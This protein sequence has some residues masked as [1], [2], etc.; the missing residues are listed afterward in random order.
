MSYLEEIKSQLNQRDFAKLLVLWEE[1]C[2]NDTV[3]V[4]EYTEILKAIKANDLAIPFGKYVEHGL[5]I[6]NLI[7]NPEEAYKVLQLILDL[8][9]TNSSALADISTDALKKKFANDPDFNER[10]RLVGLR[11][12]QNFQGSISNYEL[13]AHMKKGKYVFHTGGWDAGEIADVSPVREQLSVEFEFVAGRKHFTFPNAFKTLIPLHDDHFLSRRFANP[14]L[15]EQQARDNPNEIIHI[16]LRDLGP[17][18]AA[19]IKDE[20]CEL[21]IPEKDWTKWWQWARTKL[22]K[23]PLVET[24]QSLKQP[25]RLRKAELTEKDMLQQALQDTVTPNEIILQCYNLVRDIPAVL[26]NPDVNKMLRQS[27][28]GLLDSNPDDPSIA[29]QVSIFFENTFNETL[30]G[31]SVASLIQSNQDIPNLIDGI[32]ILAYKKR[33]LV[34]IREHRQDWIPIFL[35]FFNLLTNA[36]LRDYILKELNDGE[37]KAPLSDAINELLQSPTKNPE[38]FVWY[39]QKIVGKDSKDLPFSNKESQ[40]VFF[41]SFLILYNTLE[42]K[43]EYRELIK[44]MYAILSGQRF[45]VVRQLLEGTSLEFVKE[46]LL[47]ISKCQTLTDHD[48]KILRSL[49]EVVHPSLIVRKKTKNQSLTDGHIIWTTEEGYTKTKNKVQTIGTVDIVDNAR[50]IEAARA[51]GDLRENSEFKF[52]LERRAHLQGQL[53]F[54]SEQ[55]N[56]ARIITKDDVS[57]EEVTVG[58]ITTLKQNG[59]GDTTTYTILGPWDA[60]PENGILSF[61]SQLAQTMIGMKKGETFR[62]RDE[63]YTLVELKN[64]FE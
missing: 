49:A 55:L 41:E 32:D 4:E 15:L 21:V 27:M 48:L 39:F 33:A 17:R 54:L 46:Y 11:N 28:L 60:D 64:V 61:Q 3:D 38:L 19:E 5:L 63:D 30:E 18:T 43:P 26:K 16:L 25:F 34:A 31:R 62:F 52:A 8:Q 24:P 53:K 23:D 1:Y 40:D 22:K 58:S 51:H 47:L 59:K 2:S 50:E 57:N 13:L 6:W 42:L 36:P 14:D 35:N 45:A 29:I 10:I 20:L 9:T 44:K 7:D 56:R 37:G 12:R